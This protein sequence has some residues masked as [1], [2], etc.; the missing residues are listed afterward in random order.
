MEQFYDLSVDCVRGIDSD[1]KD[2]DPS[3]S[4]KTMDKAMSTLDFGKKL[5]VFPGDYQGV[6]LFCPE[7]FNYEI[8]GS[9]IGSNLL[10]FTHEGIVSLKVF[11]IKFFDVNFKCCNS[12]VLFKYSEFGPHQIILD[13]YNSTE[14]TPINEIEFQECIFGINSQIICIGGAYSISFK[15]CTFRNKIIPQIVAKGGIIQLN[16][17]LCNLNTELVYNKGGDVYI[18]YTTCIFSKDIWIGNECQVITNDER[19][20]SSPPIEYTRTIS[21]T[22]INES[23]TK[24]ISIDTDDISYEYPNQV[25]ELELKPD[26]EFLYVCGSHSLKV[27]LPDHI[28]I[29]NGHKIEIVKDNPLILIDGNEY[30]SRKITIRF[31]G[32]R[33]IFY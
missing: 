1:I 26:T 32:L 24:A 19:S 12:T 31:V 30:F 27:L 16:L 6:D 14:E 23:F 29:Q 20:M 2:R 21:S 11:R 28:F 8:E 18:L 17:S 15:N 13:G 22:S 4:F 9:T 3:L 10:E 5:F 7:H 33:W 25:I